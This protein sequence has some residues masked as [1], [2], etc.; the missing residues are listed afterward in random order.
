MDKD[1]TLI[2]NVPYN[3]DP[4][5]IWLMEGAIAGLQRLHAAQYLLIV[6]TNQSG[7]ARGYFPESALIAVRER[8]HQLLDKAGVP[9]AGF[10]YCPHHPQG[11][12]TNYA[13]ECECRKPYPGM[14]Y[15]AAQEHD[16]DLSQSWLIGD[17][18]HDVEAGRSAGCRTVL[19]DN[20]NETE[21]KLSQARLPHHLAA[22]LEDASRLIVTS[23]RNR[24]IASSLTALPI[25]DQ[26]FSSPVLEAN[27]MIQLTSEIAYVE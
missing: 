13:I 12:V 23:S 19:L 8:L 26:P 22:N 9:L 15:Q 16:I 18:L 10:Y 1:G 14:L 20:G 25:A 27:P 2:H 6:V 7:V 5:K 11:S 4:E 3:V 24:V 17:I 21:W